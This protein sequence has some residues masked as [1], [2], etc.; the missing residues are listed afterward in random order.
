MESVFTKQSDFKIILSTSQ[1]FIKL[2]EVLRLFEWSSYRFQTD[3]TVDIV[4][5][6]VIEQQ[7]GTLELKETVVG[8]DPD[9]IKE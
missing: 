9:A 5:L 4:V 3:G 7:I 2:L 1:L 6:R 8:E